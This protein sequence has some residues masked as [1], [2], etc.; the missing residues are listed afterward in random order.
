MPASDVTG[1]FF[2]RTYK[3]KFVI[4]RTDN[5]TLCLFFTFESIFSWT[6]RQNDLFLS[7]NAFLATFSLFIND[8]LMKQNTYVFYLLCENQKKF[9][10]DQ[11]RGKYG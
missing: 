8:K 3:P 1:A 11:L 7:V 10:I 6:W 9:K 2:H 5:L 4:G